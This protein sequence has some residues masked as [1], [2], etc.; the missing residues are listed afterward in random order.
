MTRGTVRTLAMLVDTCRVRLV[1]YPFFTLA[2]VCDR[3][4]LLL[5]GD[6]EAPCFASS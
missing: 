4:D 5:A 3:D 1:L 2:F 6:P